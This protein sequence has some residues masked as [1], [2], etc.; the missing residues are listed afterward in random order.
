MTEL[1]TNIVKS[2]THALRHGKVYLALELT[3]NEAAFAARKAGQGKPDPVEEYLAGL[4]AAGEVLEQCRTKF[5][6][7]G[8]NA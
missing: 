8:K 3:L 4:R 1:D 6:F 7:G 2:I 5:L